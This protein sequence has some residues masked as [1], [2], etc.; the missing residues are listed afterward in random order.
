[1]HVSDNL[2]KGCTIFIVAASQTRAD[3]EKLFS[4]LKQIGF[5]LRRLMI[6][7]ITLWKTFF[8]FV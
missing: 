2:L 6:Y 4:F 8:I 1:M 3:L 7:D 5:M